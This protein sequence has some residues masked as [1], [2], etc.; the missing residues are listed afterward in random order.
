MLWLAITLLRITPSTQTEADVSSQEDS[1][2]N[3][4]GTLLSQKSKIKSQ[5][6][7]AR[8]FVMS[9]TTHPGCTSLAD[10]LFSYAGKRVKT[11][12]LYL[13]S[14]S[15]P[16]SVVTLQSPLSAEGE[17]RVT[18]RSDGRVSRIPAQ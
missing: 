5:N 13:I 1:I 9:A 14:L 8:L 15:A 10:P 11:F 16:L 7:K 18:K 17:E 2:P 4:T 6:S 12:F 3:I